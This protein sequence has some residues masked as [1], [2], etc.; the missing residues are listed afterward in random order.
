MYLNGVSVRTG[1]AYQSKDAR[2]EKVYVRFLDREKDFKAVVDH[3]KL[4]DAASPEFVIEED[5]IVFEK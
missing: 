5:G 1:I 4:Y 2:L 3:L